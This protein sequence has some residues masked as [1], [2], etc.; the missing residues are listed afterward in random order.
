[1]KPGLRELKELQHGDTRDTARIEAV[2]YPPMYLLKVFLI[3][4][5]PEGLVVGARCRPGLSPAK[6]SSLFRACVDI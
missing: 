6:P 5:Y 4:L 2:A 3:L 1:M